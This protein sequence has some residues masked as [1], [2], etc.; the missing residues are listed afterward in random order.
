MTSKEFYEELAK[1]GKGWRVDEYNNLRQPAFIQ[2]VS[3]ADVQRWVSFCPITAVCWGKKDLFFNTSEFLKAGAA[4]RL[5]AAQILRISQGADFK[6][7][8]QITRRKLLKA[9][10]L[11]GTR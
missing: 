8:N 9:V 10:G 6:N 4:L 1:T 5:T 7:I 11:T 2:T 3:A